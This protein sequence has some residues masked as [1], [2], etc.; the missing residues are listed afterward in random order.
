MSSALWAF[1]I[2]SACIIIA[3]NV[4]SMLRFFHYVLSSVGFSQVITF[5][6]KKCFRNSIILSISLDLD[7]ALQ[8]CCQTNLDTGLSTGDAS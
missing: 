3:L 4:Y 5:L 6:K 1:L 7:K 2:E 8:N